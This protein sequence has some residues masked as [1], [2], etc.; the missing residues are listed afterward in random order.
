MN[1]RQRRHL[2]KADKAK[3]QD[4]YVRWYQDRYRAHR[5]YSAEQLRT[6]LIDDAVARRATPLQWAMVAYDQIASADKVTA[7]VV[8]AQVRQACLDATGLDMP[9]AGTH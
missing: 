5:S 3:A 1:R 4:A 8:F 9:F 6:I 7:E 2:S